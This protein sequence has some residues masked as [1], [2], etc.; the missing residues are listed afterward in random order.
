MTVWSDNLLVSHGHVRS[1]FTDIIYNNHETGAQI[2][3]TKTPGK[4]GGVGYHK[5]KVTGHEH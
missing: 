3:D 1:I 5:M 4:R 2:K